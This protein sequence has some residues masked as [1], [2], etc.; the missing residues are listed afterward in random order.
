MNKIEKKFILKK[1]RNKLMFCL[2]IIFITQIFL[3]GASLSYRYFTYSESNESFLLKENFNFKENKNTCNLTYRQI[4]PQLISQYKNFDLIFNS[5]EKNLLPDIK[6]IRCIGTVSDVKVNTSQNQV[7]INIGTS[8]KAFN[9][10]SLMFSII[11]L[12]IKKRRKEIIIFYSFFWVQHLISYNY[13]VNSSNLLEL[14]NTVF[15]RILFILCLE[16]LIYKNFYTLINVNNNLK[17]R[18]ELDGLRAISVTFVI[19]NHFDKTLFQYGYLGVDMFFVLSGYVIA[20]SLYSK[21]FKNFPHFLIEFYTKR[22]KR[23]YPTLFLTIMVSFLFFYRYTYNYS[24]IYITGVFALFGLSNLY[25]Y[26]SSLEYFS[27]VA[28]YNPLLHTWSLGVEEQFYL[29]FPF[30][31]FYFLFHKKNIK[32]FKYFISFVFGTSLIYFLVIFDTNFDGA[33]YLT[34]ARIWQILLGVLIYLFQNNNI[35]NFKFDKDFIVLFLIILFIIFGPNFPLNPHIVISI[36]TGMLIVKSINN[37]YSERILKSNLLTNIGVISYSLY[38][39]HLP[40]FTLKFWNI[41]TLPSREIEILFVLLFS[42]S[43]FYFLDIP[44]RF[45]G[46]TAKFKKRNIVT[47]FVITFILISVIT[48]PAES[49]ALEDQDLDET[50]VYKLIECHLPEEVDQAF[51]KCLNFQ[52]ET[53]NVIMLGDSHVTNHYF[54]IMNT[55]KNLNISLLVENSFISDFLGK[56]FCDGNRACID[57]GFDE[58]LRILNEKLIPNDK[59]VL[60][61]YSLYVNEENKEVFTKNLQKL[62]DVIEKTESR[63]YLVD[64]IPNPCLNTTDFN[65]ELE[66][67]VKRNFEICSVNKQSSRDSRGLYSEI[68][69]KYSSLEYVKYLDPH[70][71]LCD[72]E[73]CNLNFNNVLLYADTSPHLTKVGTVYLNDFWKSIDF[74]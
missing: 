14:L 51:E 45:K 74:K 32:Y 55:S 64:D 20:S 13:F 39:W 59:V 62:I 2:I 15:V 41:D 9:F 70:D 16:I 42:L 18:K 29:F 12:S 38:L 26:N 8:K 34:L 47:F 17:Y 1:Y 57:G 24:S 72:T 5:D 58:Y 61:F 7:I 28:K 48:N 53:T 27:Q 65:Y 31:L 22:F 21:S 63:L 66:V 30:I 6:S 25:L 36:L 37:K 73:N 4:K 43:T 69:L 11:F 68:I 19:L 56:N 67:L 49:F 60:G 10:I 71:Y 35:Q 52:T 54:P 50:P 44:I 40:F 3:I 46:F 33:Y 23:L